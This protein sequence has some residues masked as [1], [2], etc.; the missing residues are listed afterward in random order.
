MVLEV[1]GAGLV[2]D[3]TTRTVTSPADRRDVPLPYD[4]IT[5]I[6]SC[7]AA[8]VA[9][10]TLS[11]AWEMLMRWAIL[12][13]PGW[14]LVLPAPLADGTNRRDEGYPSGVGTAQGGACD[15]E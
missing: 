5:S 1:A 15:R 6:K 3:C 7:T 9:S 13:H 14:M 10:Q 4:P 2:N 11:E 8:G 12:R